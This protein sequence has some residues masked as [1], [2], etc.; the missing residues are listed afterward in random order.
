MVSPTCRLPS[1]GLHHSHRRDYA[2]EAKDDIEDQNL[3]DDAGERNAAPARRRGMLDPFELFVNLRCRF[4]DQK[5][6]AGQKNHIAPVQVRIIGHDR[7]EPLADER[8]WRGEAHDPTD[9]QQQQHA[10]DHRQQQADH[11]GLVL[12]LGGQPIG[13]HR[14][15]D[16]VVDPQYDFENGERH[17]CD[18]SLSTQKRSDR[19]TPRGSKNR[20][21]ASFMVEEYHVRD[22]STWRDTLAIGNG[23]SN[24]EHLDGERR[25]GASP[26]PLYPVL[27]GGVGR[28]VDRRTASFCDHRPLTLPSPLST[29]ER[30]LRKSADRR[31]K[32]S[33]CAKARAKAHPMKLEK[34]LLRSSAN[35]G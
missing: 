27:R 35:A 6:S 4:V 14:D 24:G 5:D 3:R 30:V 29:G 1:S 8:Y 9:A 28:T 25:D 32:R 7:R 22:S 33:A 23:W 34:R 15:K 13:Q 20:H 12:P 19:L 11:A 2:V 17:Q 10:H 16:D 21:E 18:Q 31:S 26:S